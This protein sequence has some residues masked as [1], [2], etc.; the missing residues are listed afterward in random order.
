M[1]TRRPTR[2]RGPRCVGHLWA[3]T[4]VLGWS[5]LPCTSRRDS[6]WVPFQKSRPTLRFRLLRRW[7][8][9]FTTWG[10][11]R[12]TSGSTPGSR[13]FPAGFMPSWSLRLPTNRTMTTPFLSLSRTALARSS[14]SRRSRQQ[15]Q[16]SPALWRGSQKTRE[17]LLR[18][19]YPS[20][21]RAA[22]LPWHLQTGPSPQTRFSP[23]TSTMARR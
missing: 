19:T 14:W 3:S 4:R 13:L 21:P 15:A 9:T 6:A 10:Q 7:V 2:T 11:G 1:S 22:L 23:P 5:P 12:T 18:G 8:E 16:A 20:V 17:P